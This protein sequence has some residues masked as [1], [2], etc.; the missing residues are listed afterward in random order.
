[1]TKTLERRQ[2]LTK[3]GLVPDDPLGF[4]SKYLEERLDPQLFHKLNHWLWGQTMA[5]N[6]KGESVVYEDDVARFLS[7]DPVVD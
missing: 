6:E 2:L 7:G 4:T 1:M 5:L 3:L